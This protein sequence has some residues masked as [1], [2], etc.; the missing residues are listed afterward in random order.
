M[1]NMPKRRKEAE[2]MD[3]IIEEERR[4]HYKTLLTEERGQF[5]EEIEEIETKMCTYKQ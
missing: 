3:L 2:N 1:K 5:K 4:A